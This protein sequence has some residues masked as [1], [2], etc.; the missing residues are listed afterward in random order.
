MTDRSTQISF[1]GILSTPV[2]VDCNGGNLTSDA[3]TTPA[4]TEALAVPGLEAA[5]GS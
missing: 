2:V 3:T 4:R 1:G 5:S